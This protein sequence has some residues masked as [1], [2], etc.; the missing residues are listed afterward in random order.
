MLAE[1]YQHDARVRV[2]PGSDVN[3]ARLVVG[4]EDERMQA[5]AADR[6][7]RRQLHAAHMGELVAAVRRAARRAALSRKLAGLRPK[8]VYAPAWH[9][10]VYLFPHPHLYMSSA[11]CAPPT[12][13]LST[14][15]PS[16]S[17]RTE[18]NLSS[19]CLWSLPLVSV[20]TYATRDSPTQLLPVRA[21][22]L[23]AQ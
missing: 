18:A 2:G 15:R 7:R 9:S 19:S 8:G 21:A 4:D 11:G 1:A 5:Q 10:L 3:D 13:T 23:R 22:I 12:T 14:S 6:A 16:L 20:A 17:E